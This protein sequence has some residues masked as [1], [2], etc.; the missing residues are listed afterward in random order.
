MNCALKIPLVSDA[1]WP[2][3]FLKG[4]KLN[5]GQGYHQFSFASG[6]KSRPGQSLKGVHTEARV[7]RETW[8]LVFLLTWDGK[9]HHI[10][11]ENVEIIDEGTG[12]V[13]SFPSTSSRKRK[14]TPVAST[15]TAKRPRLLCPFPSTS[16]R[17]RKETPVASTSTA[18]RPR[19]LC[20][21]PSF[22]HMDIS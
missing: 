12:A 13:C 16:S 21:P 15:S 20:P 11:K 5:G 17:K 1:K 7:L 14:E 8:R 19:L 2:T 6:V 3:T 18:K 10:R 9:Q 4:D 22:D